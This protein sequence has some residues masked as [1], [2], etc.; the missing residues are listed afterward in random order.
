MSLPYRLV[1]FGHFCAF[2]GSCLRQDYLGQPG[3]H[4]VRSPAGSVGFGLMGC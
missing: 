2:Y 1:F 4:D 3:G